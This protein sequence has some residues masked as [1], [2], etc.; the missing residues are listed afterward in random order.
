[1]VLRWTA[2]HTEFEW[3]T[4]PV[5]SWVSLSLIIV[6]LGIFQKCFDSL[7]ESISL[8]RIQPEENK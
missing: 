3:F 5:L 6:I 4:S 2:S 7:A 1:M 8:L